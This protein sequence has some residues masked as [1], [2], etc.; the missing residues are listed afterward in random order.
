MNTWANEIEDL[1][2]ESIRGLVMSFCKYH[3]KIVSY[4]ILRRHDIQHDD[5]QH[6]DTQHNGLNCDTQHKLHS[7]LKHSA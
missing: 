2:L 4:L 1:S 3:C 7:A 5:N 6:N